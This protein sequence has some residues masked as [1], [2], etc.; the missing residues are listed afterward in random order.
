MTHSIDLFKVM[1]AERSQ[2]DLSHA[3]HG[4]VTDFQPTVAQL[5]VLKEKHKP[6]PIV[7]L[8]SVE[9]RTN[10]DPFELIQKQLLHYF[11]VYGRG[12][13]GLFN[14]EVS[15][16]QVATITFIKAVTVEELTEK[17]HDLIY[18][19]RP[20]ADVSVV[21]AL[22]REHGLPYDINLVKNNELRVALFEPCHDK[23][24]S[25]D[26]CVRYICYKATD[27]PLLIK[28]KEVVKAVTAKPADDFFLGQHLVPLAQVFNR[29]QRLIMACKNPATRSTVNKI[30]KLSKTWHVPLHEGVAKRFIS[31]ALSSTVPISVLSG[32]PL[33]DK[34]KYLN[35]LEYILLG[36]PY[37]TFIIRNGKVWAEGDRPLQSPA[38]LQQVKEAVLESVAMDLAYLRGKRILLDPHVDYGLPISRKQALGNLPYGTRVTADGSEKLSAGIYWHNNAWGAEQLQQSYGTKSIDLDLSAI[39]ST[40][41]RTGWGQWSGYMKDAITFSGDVTDATKGAT[42]FMVVDPCRPNRYGLM[43][44]IFRGPEPCQA[45]IVVGYP[46]D[47]VWQDHTLL[48]EPI[49]LQSKQG[50]IG[51]LKDNTFVVYSGRLSNSRVSQGKHPVIDK[52]LGILWTVKD[53]LWAAGIPYNTAPEA[54]TTYDYD[55]RYA[56][57]TLDKLEAMLKI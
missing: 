37:D 27:N 22:I 57:F 32:I 52:G 44:N 39:D 21:V 20:I 24:T 55:L 17:V 33:R 30:S 16:G 29:H 42:E 2:L 4:F 5:K 10:A 28:S 14:L 38:K 15:A 12:I 26:D 7:T 19:N 18:A 56:G 54:D 8:F 31:G 47:R 41:N 49:T 50:I 25:G 13:P 35:L 6:L 3:M 11:E 45:E 53:I 46:T 1:V 51:F 48:R 40:G 9:E 23:F 34:F 43:V 36:L